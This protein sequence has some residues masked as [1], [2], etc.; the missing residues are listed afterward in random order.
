MRKGEVEFVEQRSEAGSECRLRNPW[1]EEP[2]TVYR[3]GVKVE[4][5]SGHAGTV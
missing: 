5:L 2:V 4:D 3:N 1:Q